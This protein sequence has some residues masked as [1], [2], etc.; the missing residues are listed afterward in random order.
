N[1]LN[2]K[3]FWGKSSL[4]DFGDGGSQGGKC[5]ASNPVTPSLK[6]SRSGSIKNFL[7]KKVFWG[8]S[9]LRDFGNGGS[10]GGKWSLVQ[11]Q[12]LRVFFK[13]L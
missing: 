10:L 12:S 1:F 5:A 8:K 13:S 6:K 4:R 3:V 2:K 9:S 7:N 11:I